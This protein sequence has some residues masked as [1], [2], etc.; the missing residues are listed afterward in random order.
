MKHLFSSLLVTLSCHAAGAAPAIGAAP[1]RPN[2][3]FIAIDDLK[4]MLGCYG[5]PIIKTP[6]IDRLAAAG[7]I[8]SNNHCQQAIC[9]PTR[10][11]LLTGLRPD[12]TRVWDLATRMRDEVPDVLTLPQYF[13]QQGYFTVAMGKIYDGRCCDGWDT[14]DKPSWSI[15]YIVTGGRAYANSQNS[16]KGKNE[17]LPETEKV[18]GPHP[19]T[20]AGDAPDEWYRDA[21]TSVRAVQELKKLA[22]EGKPFFLAVGFDRPHLPFSAPQHFWDLYSRAQFKLP[23]IRQLPAGAPSIAFQDS[24]ELRNQYTDVPAS[25]PI[26]DEKQL[27][28]IH[29]YHAAVSFVDAQVGRVLNAVQEL[30]L[31]HNTIIVLWGDHGFHLGDHGMF[32]KHTNYEQ[33]TRAPLILA[34][35]GQK[36]GRNVKSPTEF[37]DIFPTLCDAAGLAVPGHLQ[38]TSLLPL[39]R[40]EREAVKAFAI[41]QYPRQPG[42]NKS[43]MGYTYRSDR[44]RYVQWIEKNFKGGETEG[45][46]VAQELYDYEKD[47]EETANIA[48]RPDAAPIVAWFKS[49]MEGRSAG[50]LLRSGPPAH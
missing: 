49:Q 26:S 32:C 13:K 16:S 33:A 27:E 20:E 7:T 47:P 37:V 38:G 41:S 21:V 10:A 4:P 30:G 35:P 45:P 2:V 18:R 36:A 3:L 19:S 11:S 12:A 24:W 50:G 31:Q 34:V 22:G 43:L 14:Q 46:V 5:D 9:G 39:V 8:F 42:K 17:P 29:G 28:L 23:A 44:Y 25:G 1:A 40:G 48:D 15:P 6:N